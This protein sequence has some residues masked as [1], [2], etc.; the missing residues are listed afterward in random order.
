VSALTP[1]GTGGI[2]L[3]VADTGHGLPAEHLRHVFER[4]YRVDAARKP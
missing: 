2:D 4:F 1:A 3:A